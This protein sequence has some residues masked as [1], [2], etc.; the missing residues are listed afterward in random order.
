MDEYRRLSQE[1]FSF[2]RLKKAKVSNYTSL[3]GTDLER[4]IGKETEDLIVSIYEKI[5]ELRIKY[6]YIAKNKKYR[7]GVR[8]NNIRKRIWLLV[9]H[10]SS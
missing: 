3:Q 6:P 10:V 5:N 9:R 2:N 8:V 4:L 1:G 7:W